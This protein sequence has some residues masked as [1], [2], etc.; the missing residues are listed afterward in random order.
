MSLLHW[1]FENFDCFGA[2]SLW[3]S[4]TR[5]VVEQILKKGG[6]ARL[7]EGG[8]RTLYGLHGIFN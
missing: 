3:L 2:S 1:K 7:Y 6:W 5:I 4:S 8:M